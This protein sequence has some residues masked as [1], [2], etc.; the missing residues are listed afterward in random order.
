MQG[1]IDIKNGWMDD[2]WKSGGKGGW[3]NERI[4]DEQMDDNEWI[5]GPL[6]G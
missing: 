2:G 1:N 3:T 6:D 4:M 5:D